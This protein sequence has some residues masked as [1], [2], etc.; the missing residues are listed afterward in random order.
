MC[1]KQEDFQNLQFSVDKQLLE[2]QIANTRMMIENRKSAL[3]INARDTQREIEKYNLQKLVLNTLKNL[4]SIPD[5]RNDTIYSNRIRRG[6]QI[7]TE[8]YH[9]I[10]QSQINISNW[11]KA[12]SHK[13]GKC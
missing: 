3:S 10:N 11:E 6:I 7:N 9:I 13:T 4:K 12:T 1:R 8:N 2:Q 5:L